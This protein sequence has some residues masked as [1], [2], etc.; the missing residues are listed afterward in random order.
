MSF[1]ESWHSGA[2]DEEDGWGGPFED[3]GFKG[4]HAE[5]SFGAGVEKSEPAPETIA[6]DE[7]GDLVEEVHV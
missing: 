1:G 5:A 4:A 3:S 2:G 6:F 7:E